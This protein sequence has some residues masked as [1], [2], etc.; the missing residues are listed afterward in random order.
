M[1]TNLSASAGDT[2]WIPGSGRSGK[3]N[4][5]PLQ[6]F[7]LG[8]FHRQRSLVGYSPWG[9][10]ELDVTEQ[11]RATATSSIYRYGIF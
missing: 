10:K 8:K 4:E 7:L 11:S 3:G 1:V 5:N 9:C 6:Y 2:S